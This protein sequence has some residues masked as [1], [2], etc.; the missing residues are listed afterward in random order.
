MSASWKPIHEWARGTNFPSSSPSPSSSSPPLPSLF[1]LTAAAPYWKASRNISTTLMMT[2]NIMMTNTT[3][4]W[5]SGLRLQRNRKWARP[6]RDAVRWP[7]RAM[8]PE[9]PSPRGLRA[10]A[11]RH[12]ACRPD[13][14]CVLCEAWGGGG[15]ASTSTVTCSL[16]FRSLLALSLFLSRALSSS[17]SSVAPLDSFPVCCWCQEQGWMSLSASMYSSPSMLFSVCFSPSV[18][19]SLPPPRSRPP[20]LLKHTAVSIPLDLIKAL[21]VPSH[22]TVSFA[23]RKPE[24]WKW[25]LHLCLAAL[26]KTIHPSPWIDFCFCSGFF[27]S[28]PSQPIGWRC[29]EAYPGYQSSGGRI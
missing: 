1:L 12:T 20:A 6:C 7:P 11:R 23:K 21:E 15:R 13:P 19:L 25:L 27:S 2:S 17:S 24:G 3:T 5:A 10:N 14:L 18:L 16:P 28:Y 29:C 26:A 22:F 9:A 8:A 4:F